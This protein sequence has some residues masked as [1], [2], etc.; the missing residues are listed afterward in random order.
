VCNLGNPLTNITWLKDGVTPPQRQWGV[1]IYTQ[2]A[3]ILNNLTVEDSGT[4]TC[5]VINENG[6]KDFTYKVEV[7]SKLR[8]N[9]QY[10][11]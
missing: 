5:K 3:I 8:D 9:Y 7:Q 2:R 10:I 4:Y 11:V 1:I 6:F